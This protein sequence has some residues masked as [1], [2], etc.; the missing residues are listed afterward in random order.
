MKV[1]P[2]ATQFVDA[3]LSPVMSET[4][5]QALL[6]QVLVI[7]PALNEE[8]SLPLVLM[9]LPAVG[10]VIVVDNGS[11]DQTARVASD[12]GAIVVNEPERGYGSACLRGL[13]F[14]REQIAQ[15]KLSVPSVIVFIDADYSDHP[16]M[17]PELVQPILENKVAFV[18]GSR[19]LGQREPGAMLPQSLYGN[20]FA[21][22]LIRLLFG[23]RYTDLGPFRA[24]TY[25]ALQQLNMQDRNYGWTVEMQIKATRK[26]IK[27]LEIP[28]PYRKRIGNSK[29][30]GTIMGTLKAGYKILSLIALYAF[31]SGN[32]ES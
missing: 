28:V 6:Q 16:D 26:G 15:Q 23:A 30:S 31:Q 21:C 22:F 7:I 2:T 18:L 20:Q 32:R 4:E 12:A 9:D 25:D 11:T 24:I 13:S 17:L 29:I 1:Q 10:A 19:L 27:T 8:A 14:L 5:Q 3:G